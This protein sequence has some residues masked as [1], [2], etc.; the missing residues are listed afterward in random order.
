MHVH[1]YIKILTLCLSVCTCVCVCVCVTKVGC[2]RG[3]TRLVT[4]DLQTSNSG[5][6]VREH[7]AWAGWKLQSGSCR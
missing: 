1:Q 5:K 7:W 6:N 3:G 4:R 2:L